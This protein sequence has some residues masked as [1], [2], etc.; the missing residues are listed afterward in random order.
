M[1]SWSAPIVRA[2]TVVA[3]PLAAIVFDAWYIESFDFFR[4][5]VIFMG[6]KE[7]TDST[8]QI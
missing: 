5:H 8:N 7:L 6:L 1:F 2:C 4:R 3:E